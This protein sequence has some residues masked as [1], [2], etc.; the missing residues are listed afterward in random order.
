[1]ST[2]NGRNPVAFVCL[3]TVLAA[4]LVSSAA[5]T[6]KELDPRI[7]LDAPYQHQDEIARFINGSDLWE[8]YLDYLAPDKAVASPVVA[9]T[10]T[11][12]RRITQKTNRGDYDPGIVNSTL[13][14]KNLVSG[15]PMA[16]SQDKFAIKDFV[17]VGDDDAT[18]EEIQEAAFLATERTALRFVLR[19]LEAAVVFGMREEGPAGQAFIPVLEK[20]AED[21]LAGNM[22]G[23]ARRTLRVIRGQE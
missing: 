23:E 17:F 19:S 18:R 4:G 8:A 15:K 1:M 7:S 2:P 13:E 22:A 12:E 21:P 9:I 3:L 11:F 16:G 5:C 10:L 14:L 6:S 20:T